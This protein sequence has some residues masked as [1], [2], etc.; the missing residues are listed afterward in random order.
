MYPALSS[1][2]ASTW[3]STNSNNARSTVK[4]STS[5]GHK[6]D[7]S[8]ANNQDGVAELNASQLNCVEAGWNH[9]GKDAGVNYLGSGDYVNI[10]RVEWGVGMG[11]WQGVL[12]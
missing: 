7:R 11:L 3:T 10:P 5:N 1:S 8:N 12:Y 4:C 9:V 6:A 2:T